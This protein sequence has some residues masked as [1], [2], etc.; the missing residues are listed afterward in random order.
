[1]ALVLL[2]LPVLA[3]L[4]N[5]G[6]FWGAHDARHSV[7]FLFEFDRVFSDGT[8]YPRWMPDFTY[9][10]GYPFFNIYAP[11]AYYVGEFFHL[12]GLDLVTCVKIVF[13][14][15]L[16][17]SGATMYGL[18][19]RLIHS[20]SGAL[21]A[22]L[23]YVYVPYHLVDVYVRA[24]LAESL[25]LVFL[26]LTLWGIYETVMAPRPLAVVMASLAWAGLLF[27]HNGLALLFSPILAVWTLFLLW[28]RHPLSRPNLREGLAGWIRGGIPPA[29]SILLGLGVVGI[30]FVPL[31][32][33]YKDVNVAQWNASYYSY[34][35]HFV[36]PYQLFS[37][38]WGFGIS[39]PGPDDGL[40]FQL[41]LVPLALAMTA[42]LT[43]RGHRRRWPLLGFFWAITLLVVFLMLQASRPIWDILPLV[44]VAQFP[45]RLLG[46]T[47]VSLAILAGMVLTASEPDDAGATAL[48]ALL[49]SLLVVLGSY[50]YVQAQNVLKA[51]EGQV[52]FAGLMTFELNANEMTGITRWVKEQPT[53]S[54]LADLWMAGKKVN[55][56]VDFTGKPDSLYIGRTQ[57]GF[58]ANS[59]R[60]GYNSPEDAEITFNISYY[61]G[62]HVYLLKPRTDERIHEFVL[63]QDM[64]IVDPY[65]AIRVKVPAG[66]YFLLLTFEDT[67]ARTVGKILSAG[68]LL[69]VAGIL[70]WDRVYSR[71]RTRA[72]GS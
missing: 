17:L 53:W 2:T 25:A 58:R 50:P 49:L 12:A 11:G 62:W 35:E 54:P 27:T 24:N 8:F 5:P 71:A 36:E 69:A 18:V 45:W 16:V 48:P 30:F 38:T 61:P 46:L 22:G 57:N 7:Y 23:V 15:G 20:P 66:E 68:S 14:L 3:P 37:P 52:G 34:A 19:R 64:E 9:G 33:E 63:G 28:Q 10:Y 13:A 59:E 42:F 31:V 6:Y 51:K 65:A 1:M 21:V 32:V 70:L 44:S 41:G 29:L 40:S 39:V 26:P 72:Q 55:S 56:K 67:P 4:L 47:T 60:I 43:L